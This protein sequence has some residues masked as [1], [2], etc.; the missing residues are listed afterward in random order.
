MNETHATQYL[1]A[2]SPIPSQDCTSRTRKILAAL[3]EP[4]KNISIVKILGEAGKSTVSR[5]LTFGLSHS[6]IAC[7][8]VSLS[9]LREPRLAI[10]IGNAPPTHIEFAAAVTK[11]WRATR[12]CS[13]EQLC[14]EE[15]LLVTALVLAANADCRILLVELSADSQNSVASALT[16]PSLCILTSSS[17]KM[18]TGYLALIDTR[19][20]IVAAPQETGVT[21]F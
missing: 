20:E 6:S 17:E 2:A 16:A 18:A 10:R 1:L 19:N 12:E 3:G 13:Q 7:A 4:Q 14:Y 5:L 9:P 15:I 8:S 11:T 21:A